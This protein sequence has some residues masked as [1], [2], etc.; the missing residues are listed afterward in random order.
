L[1]LWNHGGGY[2]GICWDDSN[3]HDRLYH[4]R[5]NTYIIRRGR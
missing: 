3:Q 2:D 4:V 5:L 1:V